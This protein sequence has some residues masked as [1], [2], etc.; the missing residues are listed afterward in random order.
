M[1]TQLRKK[2]VYSVDS[3]FSATHWPDIT[4]E[5]QDAILEL[6]LS[7]LS[8]LGQYRQRHIKPSEGKRTSKRKRT[9]PGAASTEPVKS[10]RPPAPELASFIDVG[11]VAI[12]RNLE[13]LA[14]G[15]QGF[16]GTS[17][18][19]NAAANS[20]SPYSIIFVARSGQPSAFNCQLPQMVAV[21][22]KSSPSEPPTRLVGYSRPCAEK[23]SACLGIPRASA[24]GIRV[25]APMSKALVDYVQQHVSPVRVAWLD[26]A[27][28]AVYRPTQLKIDEKMVPAKKSGKA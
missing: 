24:V 7:L 1:A 21:A 15:Q 28:K 17:K 6:L 3:P 9:A 27:E 14:A 12:T 19:D 22:S 18:H 8:P 10:E 25:G 13:K 26:E 4:P 20:P 11:L 16:E 2:L 5:D 23:L